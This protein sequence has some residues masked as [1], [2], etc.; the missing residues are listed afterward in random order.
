LGE[1]L[2]RDLKLSSFSC[3]YLGL[4]QHYNLT[5]SATQPMVSKIGKHLSSWKRNLRTYLGREL[6]VKIVLTAMPKHFLTAYKLLV[7]MLVI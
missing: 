3:S 5:K 7:G 4:P 2:E 1:I 6:L